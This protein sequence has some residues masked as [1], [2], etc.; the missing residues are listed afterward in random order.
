MSDF[1]ELRYYLAVILRRWWILL[2][3]AVIGVVA[4]YM[5]SQRLSPVYQAKATLIVGQSFEATNLDNRDIQA[6]GIII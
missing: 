1:I 4:G 3:G 2:L 5:V 6:N